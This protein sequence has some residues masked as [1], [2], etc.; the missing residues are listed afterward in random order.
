MESHVFDQLDYHA[1]LALLEWQ[2][3]FG[4][5]DTICEAPVDR[6]EV[7]AAAAAPVAA[8]AK[9]E[10]GKVPP[11]PVQIDPADIAQRLAQGAQDLAGL[12]AAMAGF[13]HCEL[14]RG[15]RNLVFGAGKIG[16]P[17]MIIGDVPT[18]D[19]DM[20][21]VPFAGAAGDLLDKMLAAIDLSREDRVYTA[22]VLPWR[23]PQAR[24]PRGDEIAMLM[25]FLKRHVELVSPKVLILMGNLPCHALLAKRG[26]SR[27]RGEWGAALGLPVLPMYPPEHLLRT[28]EKKRE[29][30]ADLLSLKAKLREML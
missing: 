6:F 16:A 10:A 24:D 4:V 1:A 2:V 23:P 26:I 20:R 19:E 14:K 27:L 28:P 17:V 7:A 15:A 30:W 22:N 25:P 3:E 29:A 21:G 11:R 8:K 12:E 18:R 9:A 13:E 5:T